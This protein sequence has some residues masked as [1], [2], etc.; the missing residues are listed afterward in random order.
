[1]VLTDLKLHRSLERI[2][3]EGVSHLNNIHPLHPDTQNVLIGSIIVAMLAWVEENA[4]PN[5]KMG[6]APVFS[7]STI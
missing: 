3:N 5:C 2:V 1:M 6:T 4:S 7:K